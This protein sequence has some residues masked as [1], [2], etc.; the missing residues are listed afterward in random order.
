MTIKL[1]YPLEELINNR[2]H[3]DKT[4]LYRLAYNFS[5][6]SFFFPSA[7]QQTPSISLARPSR[8][9]STSVANVVKKF[10]QLST[11]PSPSS[12]QPK[13]L[14]KAA[15]RYRSPSPSLTR[16]TQAFVAKERPPRTNNTGN[17]GLPPKGVKP[18]SE[19]FQK[20][21]AFWSNNGNSRS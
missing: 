6:N 15:I 21:A 5:Y 10:D 14:E 13:I 11:N 9:T 8:F 4:Q 19:N 18:K 16:K 12:A 20:A 17:G 3:F 1:R 2:P 7:K